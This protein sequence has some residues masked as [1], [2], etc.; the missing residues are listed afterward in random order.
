VDLEL[1]HR[2][3]KS[4]VHNLQNTINALFKTSCKVVVAEKKVAT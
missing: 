1:T 2:Q 3:N 4:V